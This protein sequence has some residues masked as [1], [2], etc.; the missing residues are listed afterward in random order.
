V[1]PVEAAGLWRLAWAGLAEQD[2]TPSPP[3]VPPVALAALAEVPAAPLQSDSDAARPADPGAAA[4]TV[5]DAAA[6]G[7]DTQQLAQAPPDADHPA[8]GWQ[9]ALV[10]WQWD[11]AALVALAVVAPLAWQPRGDRDRAPGAAP[12]RRGDR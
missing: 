4:S 8:D 3:A 11:R 10:G 1:D 2:R 9:P 6:S 7:A 12:D 5:P